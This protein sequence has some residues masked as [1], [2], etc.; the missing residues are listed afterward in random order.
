[1]VARKNAESY[2]GRDY[3]QPFFIAEAVF[4]GIFSMAETKESMLYDMLEE[5]VRELYKI[6]AEL[7]NMYP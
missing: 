2:P 4:H 5:K 3:V 1:M 7:E 6:T